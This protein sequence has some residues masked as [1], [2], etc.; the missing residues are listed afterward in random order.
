MVGTP[1]WSVRQWKKT[2][3]FET[4]PK[5]RK[6]KKKKKKEKKKKKTFRNCE[7]NATDPKKSG[8]SCEDLNEGWKIGWI[9][10]QGEASFGAFGQPL[11]DLSIQNEPQEKK[12][13][14]RER[15]RKENFTQSTGTLRAILFRTNYI[16]SH[17]P[18]FSFNGHSGGDFAPAGRF[19][20]QRGTLAGGPRRNIRLRIYLGK[21][22][23]GL[24]ERGTDEKG[25]ENRRKRLRKEK[26]NWRKK[27]K[28]ETTAG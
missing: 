22:S 20:N 18:V 19:F 21:I 3:P 7:A 23:V 17:S 16:H 2:A 1:P 6:K 24:K 11:D 28:E 13:E 15:R 26:Q 25:R 9:W 8:V 14:E 27:K 4:T 5:K 10:S 12:R